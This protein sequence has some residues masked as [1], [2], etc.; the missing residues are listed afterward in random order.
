[1]SLKWNLNCHP[2]KT[3]QNCTAVAS[4]GTSADPEASPDHETNK[5]QDA[6]SSCVADPEGVL[7][8]V[9]SSSDWEAVTS[10]DATFLVKALVA[11]AARDGVAVHEG[12]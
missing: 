9:R 4:A 2:Y 6:P 7:V 5:E 10:S 12:T 1:M 8:N 3:R 11:H